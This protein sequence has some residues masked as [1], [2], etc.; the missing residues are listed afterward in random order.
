MNV[1]ITNFSILPM[2]EFLHFNDNQTIFKIDQ[3]LAYLPSATCTCIYA[4]GQTNIRRQYQPKSVTKL[5]NILKFITD[6]MHFYAKVFILCRKC[7]YPEIILLSMLIRYI[8]FK[9]STKKD[10]PNF[11]Y[12][13]KRQIHDINVLYMSLLSYTT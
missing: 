8:K 2:N 11:H 13:H 1:L 6:Y 9:L 7:V 3:H 12:V 10:Y 4:T 5:I